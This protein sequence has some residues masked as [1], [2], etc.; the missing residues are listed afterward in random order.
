MILAFPKIDDA[1]VVVTLGEVSTDEST[2]ST[3]V[4]S[5]QV[6]LILGDGVTLADN[7]FQNI[8]DLI[9][10]A[11]S[12]INYENI[13]IADSNHNYYSFGTERVNLG[14]CVTE[15]AVRETARLG[16]NSI[17]HTHKDFIMTLNTLHL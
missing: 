9:M 15:I 4:S 12:N 6:L 3:L 11:N 2:I 1:A 17:T 10:S 8:A 7:E 5:A 16:T 14:C 13:T